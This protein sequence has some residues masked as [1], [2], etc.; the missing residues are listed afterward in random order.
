MS[1]RRT[2][3]K[4][5]CLACMGIAVSSSF[6]ASCGGALP[7]LKAESNNQLLT[8]ALNEFAVQKSNIIV[9]R[10]PSLDNDILLVKHENGTYDALDLTCTHEGFN[11]TPT[12]DKIYCNQH[13][14]IFDLEGNVLKEPA[15][16]P[17]KKYIIQQNPTQ[18]IIKLNS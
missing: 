14:S 4:T 9:I 17:L 10:N 2:F 3:I 15:L 8:V 7:V 11:L 12:K 1:T 6:L 13:G 5:G 18:I 16:K